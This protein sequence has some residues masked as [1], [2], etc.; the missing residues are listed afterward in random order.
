MDTSCIPVHRSGGLCLLYIGFWNV[1]E[2][3]IFQYDWTSE[4]YAVKGDAISVLATT[5]TGILSSVI[6]LLLCVVF[7]NYSVVIMLVISALVL[8]ISVALYGKLQQYQLYE[9]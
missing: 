3:K 8:A 9:T 2:C 5:G 1:Y 7:Q 6:P 4:Y